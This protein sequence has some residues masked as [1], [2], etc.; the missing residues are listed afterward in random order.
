MAKKKKAARKKTL[1]ASHSPKPAARRRK[2]SLLR[3]PEPD[4]PSPK[5]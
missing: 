5:R 4:T 3:D 1:K 2:G